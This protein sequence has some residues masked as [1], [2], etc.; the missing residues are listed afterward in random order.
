MHIFILEHEYFLNLM[1]IVKY[2]VHINNAAKNVFLKKPKPQFG[3]LVS[4]LTDGCKF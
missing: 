4:L 2:L 1:L 3:E